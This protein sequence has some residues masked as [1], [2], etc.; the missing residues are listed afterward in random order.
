V[1]LIALGIFVVAMAKLQQF[2]ISKPDE[3]HHRS[4]VAA[5]Q[6]CQ[7]PLQCLYSLHIMTSALLAK[8]I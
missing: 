3:V 4:K 6:V 8:N 1:K 2:V 7:H 5:Q